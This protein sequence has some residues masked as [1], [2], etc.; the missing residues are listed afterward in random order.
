[1]LWAERYR[2]RTPVLLRISVHAQNYREAQPASCTTGIGWT[3]PAVLLD[4]FGVD[5][6]LTPSTKVKEMLDLYPCSMHTN[7]HFY[8][9]HTFKYT[10]RFIMY[11]GITKIYYRKTVGQVFSKPAQIEGT[12]QNHRS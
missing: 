6:P 1:M 11:S 5:H 9:Q 4:G 2:F 8:D 7:I 10:G 3:F 12:I